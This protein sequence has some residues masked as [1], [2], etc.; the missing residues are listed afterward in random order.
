VQGLQ[1][2]V[3]DLRPVEFEVCPG[4]NPDDGLVARIWVEECEVG[5]PTRLGDAVSFVTPR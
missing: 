2:A 1:Q 4:P 3:A 5:F